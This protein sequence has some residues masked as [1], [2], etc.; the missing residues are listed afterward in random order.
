VKLPSSIFALVL[1]LAPLAARAQLLNC[2][3]HGRNPSYDLSIRATPVDGRLLGHLERV[4][5]GFIPTPNDRTSLG[6]DPLLLKLNPAR[7]E[8]SITSQLNTAD[9]FEVVLPLRQGAAELTGQMRGSLLGNEGMTCTRGDS[10]LVRALQYICDTQPSLDSRISFR[11]TR[12]IIHEV[13]RSLNEVNDDSEVD[14][15]NAQEDR[16]RAAP[17]ALAL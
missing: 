4:M 3:S 14:E 10:D 9:E 16:Q 13:D 12:E 2:F 15:Q 17:A 5:I 6:H 11:T 1:C 8:L 7:C